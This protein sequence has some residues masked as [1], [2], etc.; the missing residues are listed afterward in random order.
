M[1]R[2]TGLGQLGWTARSWLHSCLPREVVSQSPCLARRVPTTVPAS[3]P[4][5]TLHFVESVLCLQPWR[6][7]LNLPTGQMRQASEASREDDTSQSC[8][9]R[10][11]PQNQTPGPLVPEPYLGWLYPKV[12][13]WEG[14]VGAGPSAPQRRTESQML[15]SLV[16]GFQGPH[17]PPLPEVP[18]FR[19][20]R[21]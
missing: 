1:G 18:K 16:W 4:H 9:G 15:G 6:K 7:I 14:K 13:H 5:G 20:W 21:C 3:P 12:P 8:C 11:K 10:T 2:T 17:G 19:D